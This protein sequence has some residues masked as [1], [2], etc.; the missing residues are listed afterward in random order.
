[1]TVQQALEQDTPPTAPPRAS[2]ARAWRARGA[3]F[4]VKLI[5][6][7]VVNALGVM[8]IISALNVQ[9]WLLVAITVVLL[10]VADVVYFTR[11]ALPLKYLLP[12]LFFLA[13]F[14]KTR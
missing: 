9:S 13:V 11:R 2:H 6:M 14:A 10:V 3:G 4:A 1:M 5:L 7:G 12:G 8:A